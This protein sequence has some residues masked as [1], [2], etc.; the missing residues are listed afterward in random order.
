MKREKYVGVL[1]WLWEEKLWCVRGFFSS[2]VFGS[3]CV[4]V[5]MERERFWCGKMK[6]RKKNFGV[7]KWKWK[8]KSLV[9]ILSL[10]YIV[11]ESHK[12]QTSK[13][14]NPKDQPLL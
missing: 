13:P 7:V 12:N 11:P 14:L 6:M 5:K 3:W 9:W 2:Q 4:R 1:K 8:R 10:F